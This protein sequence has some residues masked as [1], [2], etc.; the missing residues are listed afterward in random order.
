MHYREPTS[1]LSRLRWRCRSPLSD[2]TLGELETLW[3]QAKAEL[4][5]VQSTPITLTNG[6]RHYLSRKPL[7]LIG[8]GEG[9]IV[10]FAVQTHDSF[11]RLP[12]LVMIAQQTRDCA[13]QLAVLS[14]DAKSSNR[15]DSPALESA[16]PEILAANR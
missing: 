14:T 10:D 9:I 16:T 4:H 2:Y 12:Q 7:W 15:C 8:L 1:D 3:Q 6:R 5:N 11:P 13:R